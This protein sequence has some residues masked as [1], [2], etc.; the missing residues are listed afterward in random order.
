MLLLYL[1]RDVSEMCDRFLPRPPCEGAVGE[2][3]T[4]FIPRSVRRIMHTSTAGGHILFG[5]AGEKFRGRNIFLIMPGERGINFKSGSG[6]E[7]PVA[8]PTGW[9]QFE[10]SSQRRERRVHELRYLSRTFPSRAPR[11]GP[12]V[13]TKALRATEYE[14]TPAERVLSAI[15]WRA[16]GPRG[17]RGAV[18]YLL[19]TFTKA[20]KH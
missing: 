6:W 8:P 18:K 3:G 20:Q 1:H 13:R 14:I 17:E 19:L 7:A 4:L 15:E 10:I 9:K 5:A 12:L 16:S 2:G 11:G